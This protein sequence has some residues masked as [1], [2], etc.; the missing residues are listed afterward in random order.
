MLKLD[1]PTPTAA[2]KAGR[3]MLISLCCEGSRFVTPA[4]SR[5]SCDRHWVS[6]WLS[7]A[8]KLAL[9]RIS[10][11]PLAS[12]SVVACMQT[13][14][15]CRCS[16]RF[17]LVSRARPLMCL[18]QA[19]S[20]E[21]ARSHIPAHRKSVAKSLIDGHFRRCQCRM[22]AVP[23]FITLS[24]RAIMESGFLIRLIWPSSD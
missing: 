11:T 13:H 6:S 10:E 2:A 1:F 15:C 23:S 22:L 12:A 5:S 19:I 4:C 24:P 16:L 9:S 14:C 21:A 20:K 8:R 17:A 18:L 3:R 7:A